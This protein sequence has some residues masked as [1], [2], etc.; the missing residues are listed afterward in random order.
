M[1]FVL[2]GCAGS[3]ATDGI[4][5]AEP[6]DPMANFAGAPLEDLSSDDCPKMGRS[7]TKTFMSNGTE[8]TVVLEIP[9]GK[10]ENMPVVFVYHGLGDSAESIRNALDLDSF[11][12]E[13]EVVVVIPDSQSR[14]L[15][16]WDIWAGGD[17]AVL[18]DDLRTCL[19]Q[20]L[21]VDL[22]RMMV[23]GYSFG[24]LFS[25]YLTVNRSDSLAATMIMSGGT[26]P[27]LST[28]KTPVADVPAL[29]MWGGDSDL[30]DLGLTVVS[31]QDASLELSAGLIA[32][33][34]VVA[35][36]DHGN[37]HTVPFDAMDIA[38]KWLLE[39][40]YGQPS[41]YTDA[42]PDFPTYCYLP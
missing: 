16:T 33:G 32:D 30:Y 11:A 34:H 31:F 38:E 22:N 4:D 27:S 10:P 8:R 29:L 7:G 26:G 13:N 41:P 14:Y 28:Y 15:L 40:E 24:A 42:L 9:Q 1:T 35:H 5:T 39:H 37:G 3:T 23:A 12:K 18:F 6:F 19:A 2:A 25:S 17:D 36:C 20:E 21:R